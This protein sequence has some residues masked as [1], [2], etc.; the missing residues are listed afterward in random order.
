VNFGGQEG[1]GGRLRSPL[2]RVDFCDGVALLSIF[3]KG[4]EIGRKPFRRHRENRGG[5]S[6]RVEM[7]CEAV[8]PS[9][10]LDGTAR[11]MQT[12]VR[13]VG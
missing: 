11:L 8:W 10:S 6:A 12:L 3:S 13:W 9:R 2:Y 7:P 4:S 5:P 1:S